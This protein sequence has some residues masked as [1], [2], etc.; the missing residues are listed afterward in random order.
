MD[1][2]EQEMRRRVLNSSDNLGDR[3]KLEA[4]LIEAANELENVADMIGKIIDSCEVS[5]Q[6]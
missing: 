2:V 1:E 5:D 4:E 3:F 6:R